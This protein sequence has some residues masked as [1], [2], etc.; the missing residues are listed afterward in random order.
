MPLGPDIDIYAAGLNQQGGQ[1]KKIID[2]N[3][4]NFCAM[5]YQDPH[6]D[7]FENYQSHTTNPVAWNTCPFPAG[8]NEVIN[9]LVEDT[10]NFL[11]P[12]VPGGEKWK[13][14]VRFLRADEVLGGYNIFGILR[15]NQTLLG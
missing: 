11:P 6:K 7:F 1:Y 12:Y 5:V 8:S 10:G 15:N 14:E 9:Y 2:K 4:E 3:I 13:L